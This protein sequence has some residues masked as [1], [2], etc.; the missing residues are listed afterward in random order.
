MAD[1]KPYTRGYSFTNYQAD[2]PDQPLPGNRLDVELD[3]IAEASS[4]LTARV[5]AGID[6]S[7]NNEALEAVGAE[8]GKVVFGCWHSAGLRACSWRIL[9]L[10]LRTRVQRAEGVKV[11]GRR[12]QQEEDVA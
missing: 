9:L 10:W 5:N 8:I 2:V 12:R 4:E 1:P 7:I 6:V 3:N 11:A